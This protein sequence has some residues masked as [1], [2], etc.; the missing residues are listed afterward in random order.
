MSEI[1][2][3]LNNRAM[4]GLVKIGRRSGTIEDR[5]C[6]LDK[7]GVPLPFECFADGEV[8]DAAKAKRA[9]HIAFGDHRVREGR[10]FLRISKDKPTAIFKPC[11]TYA[12]NKTMKMTHFLSCKTHQT[13]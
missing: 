7:T 11:G 2:Y 8:D 4:R 10:E 12:T 1:I 9:L 3:A 6:A 5:M 13:K